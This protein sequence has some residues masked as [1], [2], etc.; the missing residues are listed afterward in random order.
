[1]LTHSVKNQYDRLATVY[2]RWW[3]GYVRRSLA[4]LL[5]RLDRPP[6]G[7]LLDV[8]CGTGALEKRLAHERP[9]WRLTGV[10]LS[11]EMLSRARRK[12]RDHPNARFRQASAEALPFPDDHFDRV[13]SASAL[14]YFEDPAT[15]LREMHRVVRPGGRVLVLDWCRDFAAMKLLDAVLRWIDPAHRRCY[16]LGEAR[17]MFERAGLSVRRATTHRLPWWWHLMLV[18]AKLQV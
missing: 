18:E 5:D 2:D 7:R 10:D 9:G 3:H 15:A 11:G 8:G 12:L 6:E 14:H 1:V 16:T 4:V 17:R 13:V